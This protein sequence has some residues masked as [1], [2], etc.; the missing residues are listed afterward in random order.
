MDDI[1][2]EERVISKFPAPYCLESTPYI[3]P[4]FSDKT[5]RECLKTGERREWHKICKVVIIGDVS[6]GKTCL[7]NRYVV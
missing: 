7:V 2:L 3:R 5:R 1:I 4:D 6:V